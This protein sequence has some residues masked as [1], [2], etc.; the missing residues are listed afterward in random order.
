M[1]SIGSLE[2]GTKRNKLE[3]DCRSVQIHQKNVFIRHCPEVASRYKQF[4]SGVAKP[5]GSV[6]FKGAICKN[7]I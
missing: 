7:F 4:A 3:K 5:Q 2:M 1:E 6:H